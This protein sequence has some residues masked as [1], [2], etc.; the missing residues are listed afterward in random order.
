MTDRDAII[1]LTDEVERWQQKLLEERKAHDATRESLRLAGDLMRYA[2]ERTDQVQATLEFERDAYS[3]SLERAEAV[4]DFWE[5]EAA[6]G[7][8]GYLAS[9]ADEWIW[10][11]WDG[12]TG[13]P[14]A[15]YVLDIDG[16]LGPRS[17]PRLVWWHAHRRTR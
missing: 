13:I 8:A 17:V 12:A 5:A 3:R 2:D 1:E 14:S 6:R 16:G 11:D 9:G 15:A 4:L 7:A 10:S